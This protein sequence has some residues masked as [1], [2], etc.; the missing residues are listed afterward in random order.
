MSFVVVLKFWRR[1][2][3]FIAFDTGA[4]FATHMLPE[5]AETFPGIYELKFLRSTLNTAARG[6]LKPSFGH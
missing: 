6:R 2:R 3:A 1:K 4:R 5:V